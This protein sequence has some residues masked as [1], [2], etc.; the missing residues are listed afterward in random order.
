MLN[1]IMTTIMVLLHLIYQLFNSISIYIKLVNKAY[2]FNFQTLI[3]LLD[4]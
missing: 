3:V 4:I 1:L 2:K